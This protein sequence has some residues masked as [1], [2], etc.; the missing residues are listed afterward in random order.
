M[1]RWLKQLWISQKSLNNTVI[2]FKKYTLL[3]EAFQLPYSVIQPI[4]DYYYESFKKFLKA[5]REK[6]TPKLFPE[7]NFELDFSGTRYEFLNTMKPNVNVY[8][9]FNKHSGTSAYF[10]EYDKNKVNTFDKTNTG[11][12]YINLTSKFETMYYGTIEHEVLHYVQYLIKKYKKLKKRQ[13]EYGGLPSKK[14]IPSG[15]NTRGKI[16]ERRTHH[17]YRPIEYYTNLMSAIRSLE[18]AYEREMHKDPTT[19]DQNIKNK[20]S[21][22][23][24]LNYVLKAVREGKAGSREYSQLLE[25]IKKYSPEIFKK[26]LQIIYKVFVEGEPAY[27]I[28]EIKKMMEELQKVREKGSEVKRERKQKIQSFSFY[29][30][31]EMGF[32]AWPTYDMGWQSTRGLSEEI[33][34]KIEA[35]AEWGEMLEYNLGFKHIDRYGETYLKMPTT[36]SGIR[37]F[38]LDLKRLKERY[39]LKPKEIAN[40][41]NLKEVDSFTEKEVAEIFDVAFKN[42]KKEYIRSTPSKQEI[43]N[44]INHIYFI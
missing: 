38:F 1:Q 23:E 29:K 13:D 42:F 18:L 35:F 16:K 24:F 8:F 10:W 20:D 9:F 12:I 41:F 25:K 34:K 17:E 22:K 14:I 2:S 40:V 32:L 19:Y 11:N 26:Y 7:K 31:R 39:L 33:R 30:D 21:K 44:Y 15:M 36:N 3:K 5:G 43:E 37:N 28:P 6:V 4:L 27:N